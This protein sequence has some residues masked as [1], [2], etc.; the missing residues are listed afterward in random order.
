MHLFVKGRC[1]EVRHIIPCPIHLSW[2]P[3]AGSAPL[4]SA[5]WFSQPGRCSFGETMLQWNLRGC[6]L[7]RMQHHK[8]HLRAWQ[9]RGGCKQGRRWGNYSR[10]RLRAGS[11]RPFFSS[12]F[13]S[14]LFSGL[15]FL[16][17]RGTITRWPTDSCSHM[18]IT[19]ALK[20]FV[21]TYK[22]NPILSLKLQQ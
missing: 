12:A 5:G 14:S 19:Q 16:W 8:G 6:C 9:Q 3:S 10:H 4:V 11:V 18:G 22:Q 2:H 7:L 20:I 15:C 13:L 21:K 1:S 17:F